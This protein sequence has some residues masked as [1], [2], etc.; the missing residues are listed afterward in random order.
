MELTNTLFESDQFYNGL[1]LFH[2][3]LLNNQNQSYRFGAF[4]RIKN[5]R[6]SHINTPYFRN[7]R[8]FGF[9][10]VSCCLK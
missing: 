5:I 10:A 9:G 4:T 7:D 8:S 3:R 1:K 2:F 6:L